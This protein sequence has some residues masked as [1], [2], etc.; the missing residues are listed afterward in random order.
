MGPP[1]QAPENGYI[2]SANRSPSVYY[3]PHC[4]YDSSELSRCAG[5][6]D[7]VITP[8]KKLTLPIGYTIVDGMDK[9]LQLCDL[10]QPKAA[11]PMNNADVPAE[12][13]LN[14]ILIL[15]GGV[16]E[17]RELS[18]NKKWKFMDSVVPG[19]EVPLA[20]K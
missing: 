11:I 19:K 12:G 6:I 5:A 14:D 15:S 13:V 8:V 3:E 2:L 4:M 9:A 17:F 10:V 7:Y 20:V 1:W 16:R 18:R